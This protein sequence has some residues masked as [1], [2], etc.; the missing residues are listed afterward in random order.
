MSNKWMIKTKIN[1]SQEGKKRF[2]IG[3]LVFA[4]TSF[5]VK[6]INLNHG[7]AKDINN[8]TIYINRNH[9]GKIIGYDEIN[10]IGYDAINVFRVFNYKVEYSFA[11]GL[12][13]PHLLKAL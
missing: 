7:L 1:N 5:N 4:D 6:L 2:P 9:I 12:V 3:Q 10:I 11:T 8:R 13:S